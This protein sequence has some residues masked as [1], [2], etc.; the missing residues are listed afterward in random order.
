MLTK[1]HL[2][3]MAHRDI[4]SRNSFLWLATGQI[5]GRYLTI[6]VSSAAPSKLSLRGMKELFRYHK[7][8]LC[9]NIT[10][11]AL[12]AFQGQPTNT[13]SATSNGIIFSKLHNGIQE[14]ELL[15]LGKNG[16]YSKVISYQLVMDDHFTVDILDR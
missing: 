8:K 9:S 13:D 7:Y 16:Q 2:V 3:R 14:A 4:M 10:F 5:C 6:T 11:N 12:L 1:F 15:F